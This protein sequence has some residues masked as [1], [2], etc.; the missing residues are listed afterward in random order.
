MTGKET[1]DISVLQ[2]SGNVQGL[3]RLLADRRLEFSTGAAAAL[4]TMDLNSRQKKKAQTQ[5]RKKIKQLDSISPIFGKDQ[6][7]N[8]SLKYQLHSADDYLAMGVY[9]QSLI[10][11]DKQNPA[12]DLIRSYGVWFAVYLNLLRQQQYKHKDTFKLALDTDRIRHAQ[13]EQSAR[14]VLSLGSSS[15]A[16]FNTGFFQLSFIFSTVRNLERLESIEGQKYLSMAEDKGDHDW[17]RSRSVYKGLHPLLK[18]CVGIKQNYSVSR[19]RDNLLALILKGEI[20]L[21]NADHLDARTLSRIEKRTDLAPPT[22]E[23]KD[24]FV[25]IKL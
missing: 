18:Q 20:S 15:Q 13:V 25:T 10:E 2:K 12:A 19:L 24:W 21:T 22:D 8:P 11:M 4:A 3:L 1:P 17:T 9:Q 14:R 23:L 6:H 7:S 5:I 16:F